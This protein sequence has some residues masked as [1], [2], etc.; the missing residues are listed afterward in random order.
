MHW[1]DCESPE[2]TTL[3][4][5]SVFHLSSQER[6][7]C[8][9]QVHF[10]TNPKIH[11]TFK[12]WPCPNNYK[13]KERQKESAQRFSLLQNNTFSAEVCLIKFNVFC[14]YVLY[15]LSCYIERLERLW[16]TPSLLSCGFQ[17]LL[18]V[19][20][21]GREADHSPPSSAQV[22]ECIELYLHSNSTPS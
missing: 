1:N 8:L 10:I 13:I 14:L 6:K 16:G 19:K 21:L 4:V 22:K 12:K 18:G 11:E 5:Q 7:F 20:Q 3:I 17:G 9:I 2:D 15:N